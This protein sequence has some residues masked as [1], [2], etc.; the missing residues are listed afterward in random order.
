MTYPPYW[1]TEEW[2]EMR[3]ERAQREATLHRQLRAARDSRSSP[4]WR[5]PVLAT[6]KTWMQAF[7]HRPV[8]EDRCLPLVS[9]ITG[10]T[11]QRVALDPCCCA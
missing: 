1:F 2:I 5:R 3:A 8:A 6:L 4:S 11:V 7:T 10:E 9:D